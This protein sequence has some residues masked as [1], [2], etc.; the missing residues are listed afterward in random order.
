V[1]R[2]RFITAMARKSGQGLVRDWPRGRGR[3]RIAADR[4]RRWIRIAPNSPAR[5]S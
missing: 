3:C 5:I 4:A 1:V 2:D